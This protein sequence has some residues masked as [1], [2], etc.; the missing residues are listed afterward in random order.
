MIRNEIDNVRITSVGF[1][2]PVVPAD[3]G[4][5]ILPGGFYMEIEVDEDAF[6]I[7][8]TSD[9]VNAI[10]GAIKNSADHSSDVLA[11]AN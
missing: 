3:E 5:L 11:Q 9:I 8:V 6:V 1:S 7:P 10:Q 4:E 2:E